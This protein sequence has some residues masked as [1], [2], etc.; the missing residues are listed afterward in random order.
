MRVLLLVISVAMAGCS[1]DWGSVNLVHKDGGRDLQDLALPADT[2]VPTDSPVD[3]CKHPEVEKSCSAINQVEW[4]RI[5]AGCFWMGSP[6][7]EH[8]REPYDNFYNNNMPET[9]HPV[10]LTHDFE[11]MAVE[12]TQAEYQKATGSNPSYFATCGDHCPVEQVTWAEAVAYCN[13]LS[14]AAEQCFTCATDPQTNQLACVAPP[15]YKGKKIYDCPG[16]RLPTEA[17]WEYAYRA[18]SQT[19]L[20]PSKSQ[21][22]TIKTC[23]DDD[24]VAEIAWYREN[25]ESAPH[26]VGAKEPNAW[27]L[28]DMAG[29]VWE[30]IHDW[31]I[32]D[33]QGE[34][35]QDPVGPSWGEE[36]V[37]RG[38]GIYNEA[39][40][41]RAAARLGKRPEKGHLFLGFRCARSILN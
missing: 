33:L 18:G 12:V 22:G 25:A 1:Y 39:R 7:S 36:R 10:T 15:A 6:K 35:D 21:D 8:C 16:Y 34:P 4:C 13:A 11:I 29:N 2:H 32:L 30:H 20:Y 37:I 31:F 27:G 14:P 28:Y 38:G 9:R 41:M 5:P 23:R 19:P 24:N 40:W 26:P 17:E 3:S